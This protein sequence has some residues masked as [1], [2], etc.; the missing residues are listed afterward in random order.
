MAFF[1]DT[2]R[3]PSDD[4]L[5]HDAQ[6]L[7]G[8]LDELLPAMLLWCLHVLTGN[9]QNNSRCK[10]NVGRVEPPVNSWFGCENEI[11]RYSPGAEELMMA[12]VLVHKFYG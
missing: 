1:D 4:V 5:V 9:E 3:F 6:D 11:G 8:V 12:I 10:Y 7:N 2:R